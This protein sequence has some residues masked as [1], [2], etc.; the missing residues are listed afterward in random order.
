MP[1]WKVSNNRSKKAA[2][3]LS[4]LNEKDYTA[5]MVFETM[6]DFLPILPDENEERRS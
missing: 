4:Q 6:S 5:L 2:S 3:L 1:V